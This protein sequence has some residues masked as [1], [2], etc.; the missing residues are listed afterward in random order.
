MEK[1]SNAVYGVVCLVVIV[2]LIATVGIPVIEDA[3]KEQIS[4]E[5]NTT[6]KF[7]VSSGEISEV[8]ISITE[9]SLTVNDYVITT[10]GSRMVAFADDFFIYS[11]SAT[12]SLG[13][14]IDGT[15]TIVS[16]LTEIV[17]ND[18]NK[19]ISYSSSTANYTGTLYYASEKGDYGSFAYSNPVYFND[20]SI[21]FFSVFDGPFVN[22]ELSPNTIRGS[23]FFKG[24]YDDLQKMV[25]IKTLNNVSTAPNAAAV[26]LSDI[27]EVD[28][29]C[30]ST[31]AQ[32]LFDMTITDDTGTYS[33]SRPSGNWYQMIA[34]I[35]YQYISDN[36]SMIVSLLS[37]IPLVL[38]IIPV[39]I[40]VNMMIRR[41]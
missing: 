35:E 29:I 1:I 23:V 13:L 26:T 5:Q 28:S 7:A 9:G 34:P 32:T 31:N 21:L 15:S 8:T 10:T 25:A 20:D 2:I 3:Q 30:K 18:A 36:D 41:D 27:T 19:T 24:T 6:E 33:Y 4:V 12:S 37:V 38:L 16:G 11:N 39:M 14:A 22:N 17:I 40:A